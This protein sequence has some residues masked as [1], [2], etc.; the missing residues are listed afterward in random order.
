MIRSLG[1]AGISFYALML[2]ENTPLYQKLSDTEKAQMQD[3][4]REY[5]TYTMIT[6]ELSKSGFESLELT[7]LV[8]NKLDSYAYMGLRH[9][10]S[11]CIALGHGAGGNIE[12]Y[13]YHNSYR[14]PMI[15]DD[16][17]ISG[18]GHVYTNEYRIMDEFTYE[19]QKS[20]VDLAQYSEYLGIRLEE[21]LANSVQRMKEEGLIIQNGSR[22]SFTNKGRFW[23]NNVID[24]FVRCILQEYKGR[25]DINY[26]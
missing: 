24:E 17:H 16:I 26:Q 15:S 11:S 3:M 6:E 21:C 2:H 5:Y 10:G 19:L 7:K 1:I 13:H 14:S 22:L 8:R 9:K 23:G 18:E 25:N 4:E 20:T 12:H